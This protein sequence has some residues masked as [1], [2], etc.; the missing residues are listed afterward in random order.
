MFHNCVRS[1]FVTDNVPD[2]GVLLSATGRPADN[3]NFRF[4][5]FP[6]FYFDRQICRCN[7]CLKVVVLWDIASCSLVNTDLLF[8]GAYCL[9]HQGHMKR[10]CPSETSESTYQ[11]TW[12]KIQKTVIF[13][14]V[15][16]RTW[17]ITNFCAFNPSVKRSLTVA[18]LAWASATQFCV[19]YEAVVGWSRKEKGNAINCIFTSLMQVYR[20]ASPKKQT[21]PKRNT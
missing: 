19:L 6:L 7:F 1:V 4:I 20:L 11:T 21:W 2:W 15:A 3:D 16:V 12:R 17:N 10:V 13:T 18:L 14:L 5:W 8:R 9:H